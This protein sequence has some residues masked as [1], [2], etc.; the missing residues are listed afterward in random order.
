MNLLTCFIWR[1][2]ILTQRTQFYLLKADV[3]FILFVQFLFCP[4]KNSVIL[5]NLIFNKEIVTAKL[6]ACL[7][8]IKH[9]AIKMY[10]GVEV[11]LQAC[12]VA[13][14]ERPASEPRRFVPRGIAAGSS[15]IR[16]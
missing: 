9:H 12:L 2:L 13:T 15:R 5:L 11:K 14:G 16:G 7:R 8:V 4:V 3:I 1:F 10:G 6:S